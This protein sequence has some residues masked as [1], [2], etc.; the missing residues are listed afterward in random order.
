MPRLPWLL[1]CLCVA[2]A[3]AGCERPD[4]IE[5]DPRMPRLTHKGETVRLHGKL[6]DRNGHIFSTERASWSSRDPFVAA[7]DKDGLVAA[8]SS[9]Q[10]VIAARW[11][12]LSAEVR[13]EIDLVEALRV[14]PERVEL[15]VSGEPVKLEALALGLDGRPLR[16]R[17]VHLASQNPSVARVDPEGRVWGLAPGEAVVRAKLDDKEAEVHVVV[18]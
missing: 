4:H 15:S 18:K 1:P 6:M 12:E 2:L 8:L 3:G 14:S 11:N 13:V 5:I 7:V 17:A 16:D 9:G 10:T